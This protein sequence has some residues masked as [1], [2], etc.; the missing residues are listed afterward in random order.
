MLFY[1]GTHHPD[2]LRRTDV[3]LFVSRA[4]LSGRL[5]LPRA[6]GPWA[7]DSGAFS[8]LGR[9]GR[10]TVKPRH[11]AADARRWH[12]EVGRLQ[13]AAVQDWVCEGPVLAK[14]GLTVAEHQAR[15]LASYLEL[16]A[17]APEVPWLPVLQ[18]YALAEYLAHLEMYDRAGVRLGTLPAVGLGSLCRRQGTRA[19]AALVVRLWEYGLSLHAFGFKTAGLARVAGRLASAD[20]MAWSAGAR[21][22]RLRLPGHRHATCANCLD[23]A[24]AWRRRVLDRTESPSPQ[25]AGV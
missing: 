2:W 13:W 4:R 21:R 23:Y 20:S 6:R 8:E 17:L 24:L 11:Y 22:R 7:L 9:H 16:R 25:G 19:A 5:R 18:G 1:L 14:T 12:Y 3:P 15:T 10:W